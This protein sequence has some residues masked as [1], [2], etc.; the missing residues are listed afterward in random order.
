M[1]KVDFAGSWGKA[2]AVLS[3]GNEQIFTI[4]SVIGVLVLVGSVLGFIWQRRRGSG[5]NTGAVVGAAV[6]GL[7]FCAPQVVIPLALVFIDLIV[8]TVIHL[9]QIHA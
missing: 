5:G 1:E 7:F 2:W 4:L 3:N 6:V 8:N 9:A